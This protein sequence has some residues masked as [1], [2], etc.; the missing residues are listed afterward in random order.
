MDLD[1]NYFIIF[2]NFKILKKFMKNLKKNLKNM[3]KKQK[4]MFKNR[5]KNT[6]SQ[7]VQLNNKWIKLTK[8]KQLIIK[9][10]L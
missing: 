3:P 5:R 10:I 6:L 4:K 1:Y 9:L 2:Q 7:V 8:C